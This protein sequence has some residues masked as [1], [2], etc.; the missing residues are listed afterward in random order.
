MQE[1]EGGGYRGKVKLQVRGELLRSS[2]E[3]LINTLSPPGDSELK[4]LVQWFLKGHRYFL[5]SMD[6]G[7]LGGSVI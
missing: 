4:L 2:T 3:L 5:S 1:K 6:W 7:P